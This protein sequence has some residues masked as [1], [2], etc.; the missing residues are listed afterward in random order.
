MIK[1]SF[2]YPLAHI[3]TSHYW[4]QV[5]ENGLHYTI[6]DTGWG[7]ALWGEIYG[8][9][10]SGSGIYIYDLTDSTRLKYFPKHWIITLPHYAVHRQ[11]TGSSSRR[12]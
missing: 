11:C 10:I 12:T 1:H 7:K 3:V 9:W 6:A 4:H 8:P 2:G 5:V